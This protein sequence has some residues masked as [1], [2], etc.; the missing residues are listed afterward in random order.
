MDLKHFDPEFVRES[1]PGNFSIRL[2]HLEKSFLVYFVCS[3]GYRL[4]P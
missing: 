1:V 2:L 4:L 3:F